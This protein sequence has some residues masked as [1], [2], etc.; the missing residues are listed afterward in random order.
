MQELYLEHYDKKGS[1]KTFK[2]RL[3]IAGTPNLFLTVM[4]SPGF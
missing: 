2:I 1:T 4:G 3:L